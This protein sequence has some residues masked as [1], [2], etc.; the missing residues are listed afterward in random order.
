MA[1]LLD[2]VSGLS[3]GQRCSLL[4][5]SDTGVQLMGAS[6]AGATTRHA[7][8]PRLHRLARAPDTDSQKGIRAISFYFLLRCCC[9]RS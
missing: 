5:G 4:S 1:A 3:A 9:P 6:E 8:P 7:P 2:L